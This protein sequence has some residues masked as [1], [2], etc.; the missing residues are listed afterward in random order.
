MKVL[1]GEV[2]LE[3]NLCLFM[4]SMI[5]H[6]LIECKEHGLNSFVALRI[7]EQTEALLKYMEGDFDESEVYEFYGQLFEEMFDAKD[8]TR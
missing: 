3:F 2:V 1:S 4:S 6:Q 5:T 8:V 7:K